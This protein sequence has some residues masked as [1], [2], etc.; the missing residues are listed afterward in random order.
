M[1]ACPSGAKPKPGITAG[2]VMLTAG[3]L[4]TDVF[5]HI[6]HIWPGITANTVW[7]RV[8]IATLCASNPSDPGPPSAEDLA[9]TAI[10]AAQAA[11][12]ST[13][14]AYGSW[15]LAQLYYQVFF[16]SCECINP[17]ELVPPHAPVPPPTGEPPWPSGH[18]NQ[19]ILTRIEDNQSTSGD[20]LRTLYN[21]LVGMY[22]FA[23]ETWYRQAQNYV[24]YNEPLQSWTM[25]GEGF[26][27]LVGFQQ[28]DGGSWQ[29]VY[30]VWIQL[31]SVPASVAQRGSLTPR[32]YGVGSVYWDAAFSPS[33]PKNIVQRDSIHYHSQFIEAPRTVQ[34]YRL[35]WRLMPGVVAAARQLPRS[36]DSPIYAP[37]G[38]T[39]AAYQRF[40]PMTPPP[41]WSDPPFYPVGAERR[42]FALG[43]PP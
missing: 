5:E 31:E 28:I 9:Y 17:V 38:P 7:G 21:G 30:G 23:A 39:D 8:D 10:L 16:N 22:P 36:T 12:G 37:F 4:G 13:G 14:G 1:P 11:G 6:A 15:A 25:Q 40:A 35:Y 33:A 26:Q 20:A 34:T 2:T 19:D 42:I 3:L 29:E 24:Q 43:S 41:G 18:D 27:D 32:L